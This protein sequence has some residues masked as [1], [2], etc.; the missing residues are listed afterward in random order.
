MITDKN[1]YF[2]DK[3]ELKSA[4]EVEA[5]NKIYPGT[6]NIGQGQPLKFFVSL[7]GYERKGD[8]KDFDKLSVSFIT[9]SRTSVIELP[10]NNGSAAATFVPPVKFDKGEALAVKYKLSSVT[11][12]N[13]VKVTSFIAL[14]VDDK[15]T[16]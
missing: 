4:S 1:L 3:Q 10:V 7:S 12:T 9:G 11:N 13:S 14:D 15:V 16:A 2:S 5:E 6:V 8:T